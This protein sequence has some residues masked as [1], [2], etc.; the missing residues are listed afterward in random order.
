MDLH[1]IS[2]T[3][4][5]TLLKN[6]IN[7]FFKWNLFEIL[8][9]G[10]L[11]I[12]HQTAL[13]YTYGPTTTGKINT[14]FGLIYS[15][16]TIS[17]AGSDSSIA[18]N[19]NTPQE[20]SACII[21]IIINSTIL[22]TI[23]AIGITQQWIFDIIPIDCYYTIPLIALLETTR[24]T[25]K[26][27]L[28]LHLETKIPSIVETMTMIS[29]LIMFWCMEYHYQ[30]PIYNAIISLL[31]TSIL[32]LTVLLITF[33]R[34]KK[35]SAAISH[36]LSKPHLKNII[37]E[38]LKCTLYELP[39]S[40]YSPNSITPYIAITKGFE[41][42]GISKAVIS[43]FQLYI[44]AMH[45][46]CSM[47]TLALTAHNKTVP[48]THLKTMVIYLKKMSLGAIAM[49][50]ILSWIIP[51]PYLATLWIA[52]II[53]IIQNLFTIIDRT[54]STNIA[55]SRLYH[56]SG[57]VIILILFFIQKELFFYI[58]ILLLAMRALFLYL[59]TMANKKLSA[60]SSS[61]SF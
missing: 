19:I 5:A 36:T 22:I 41:A 35:N 29:Y 55:T 32:S 25:Y 51:R 24:K 3:M 20:Y 61:N 21:N 57:P 8:S 40:L 47:Q 37:A 56:I 31:T 14:L 49:C 27:I 12:T 16:V 53:L 42:A 44:S 13:L 58:L 59:E 48:F 39:N 23:A 46:I 2:Y 50:I 26:H 9:Y 4:Q 60:T 28:Q 38:R 52:I 6:P 43:F 33:H 30:K 10:T 45:K 18:V 34:R 7:L 54:A 15:A 11:L 17:H 1:N